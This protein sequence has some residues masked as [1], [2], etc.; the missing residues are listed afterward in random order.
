MVENIAYP[1]VVRMTGG[2]G[3]LRRALGQHLATDWKGM[4][5]MTDALC[6]IVLQDSH[7]GCVHP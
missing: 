7:A 4:K 6:S 1:G 5:G 2:N 3:R